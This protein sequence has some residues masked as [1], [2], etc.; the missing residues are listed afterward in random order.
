M[1]HIRMRVTKAGCVAW[2]VAF[3]AAG[4]KKFTITL[5]DK[6]KAL[7]FM[8][9]R[10]DEFRANPEAM[11]AYREKIYR[12]MRKHRLNTYQGIVRA[13]YKREGW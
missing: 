1:G 6:A 3:K 9:T 7:D 10:E 5:E 4:S 13:K 8:F 2:T 11:F 12:H